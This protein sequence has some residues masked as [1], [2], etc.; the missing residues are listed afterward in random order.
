MHQRYYIDILKLKARSVGRKSW[1]ALWLSVTVYKGQE[2]WGNKVKQGDT[3]YL[4][5]EDSQI[6]MQN[7]LFDIID[8]ETDTVNFVQKVFYLVEN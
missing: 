4:C 7:R 8:E 5:F 2:V 6:R 1:L 3:L